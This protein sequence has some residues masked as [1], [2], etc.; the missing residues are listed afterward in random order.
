MIAV[1]QQG[2]EGSPNFCFGLYD[3]E[4]DEC[5]QFVQSDWDYAGLASSLGWCPCECGHTDGTVDCAHKTASQMLSDAFDF[6]SERDG[7]TFEF[8]GGE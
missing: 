8:D 2:P 3:S 1:L 7:E 4:G 5:V 6:L